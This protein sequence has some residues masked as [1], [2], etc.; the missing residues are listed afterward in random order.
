MCNEDS[1]CDDNPSGHNCCDCMCITGCCEDAQCSPPNDLCCDGVCAE[2]CNDGDCNSG[3]HCCDGVC[4]PLNCDGTC[5][6]NDDCGGATPYCC[7]GVCQECCVDPDCI[8][9][10]PATRNNCVGGVCIG[11]VGENDCAEGYVCCDGTCMETDCN[12]G[13]AVAPPVVV[14]EGGPGTELKA[15]LALVGIKASPTC[16]CNKRAKIM[17]EQGVLWC[18]Q[19]IDTIAGWLKEES[20]KRKLPFIEAIGRMTIRLAIRNA[21]KKGSK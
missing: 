15:L 11:C 21:K 16:S 19:N 10:F 17:D 18:E 2:C 20:A 12:Q 14:T 8:V 3:D 9:N 7:N 4:Q 13:M 1:D 5:D 6:N